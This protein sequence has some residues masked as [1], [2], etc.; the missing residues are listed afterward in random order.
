VAPPFNILAEGRFIISQLTAPTIDALKML[1]RKKAKKVRA[2]AVNN[3]AADAI[4]RHVLQFIEQS[5]KKSVS[6]YLA[7]GG[8]V[9]ASVLMHGLY[10]KNFTVCLP[11]VTEID[12]PL[13]FRYWQPGC[14]LEKGP[15]ST[16]HPGMENPAIDPEIML[17]PM[18]AYDDFGNRLGWGGG[19]FDRT[20]K[21]CRENGR[22]VIT[23]GLAYAAQQCDQLPVDEFDQ[24]LD[25]VI[26]E[27]GMMWFT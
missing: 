9:D 14:V 10:D 6:A 17:L 22:S 23:V 13:V 2:Q 1:A 24:A 4:N 15:F 12:S 21:Q 25:G 7:I 18:L 26:T 20:L 16:K 27:N 8:E 11:V 19:Y 3:L 5:Q